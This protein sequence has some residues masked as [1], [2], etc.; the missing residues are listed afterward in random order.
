MFIKDMFL[1]RKPVISFEI[2]P[3][4]KDYPIET[5]YD[6]VEALKDLRPDFISVTYGAGGS[7]RD[8]TLEI[9]SIIKNKYGIEALAHLTCIASTKNEIENILMNFKKHNISNILA[10]RGDIPNDPNFEFPNPLH[11]E[12]AKDLINHI[13]EF[14]DFSVA[15]AAYPEGHIE[16][17]NLELDIQRL[18]DKVNAGADFLITQLFFDNELFYNF[19]EKVVAKNI[20]IPIS[21]GIMPVLNKNQIERIISLCGTKLPK[22]FVRIMEKYEHNPE[23]LKEA[24][25]AYATEQIIDLLSWGVDGIHLYTMNRPQTTRRII[26]NI[27]TIRDILKQEEKLSI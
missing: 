6:T 1:K 23:A 15:A 3:P 20:T 27:S 8:R 17:S 19:K 4:K 26:D 16:C 25:I 13:R 18:K 9:A 14:K 2:F 21:A 10:L 5:I 7:N 24:G 11:Y 12:Y 22:K